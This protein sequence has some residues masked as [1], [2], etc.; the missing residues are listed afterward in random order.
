[1]AGHKKC[2]LCNQDK[3]AFTDNT[4]TSVTCSG[5]QISVF[6]QVSANPAVPDICNECFAKLIVKVGRKLKGEVIP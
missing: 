2:D 5:K 3:E 1:M 6:V 4:T